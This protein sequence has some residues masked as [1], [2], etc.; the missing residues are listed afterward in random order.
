M[1]PDEK[2]LQAKVRWWQS[3]KIVLKIIYYVRLRW[4]TTH[5]HPGV[6]INLLKI[7]LIN[8]GSFR[9]VR[10]GKKRI[11]EK[12]MRPISILFWS[13]EK[14][15]VV[16]QQKRLINQQQR[17]EIESIRWKSAIRISRHTKIPPPAVCSVTVGVQFFYNMPFPAHY[18]CFRLP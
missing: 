2:N 13:Q 8:M 4:S 18:A 1:W 17:A 10:I 9:S 12:T 11:Q 15:A 16:Q 3:I 14:V 6:P 7:Q 5:P